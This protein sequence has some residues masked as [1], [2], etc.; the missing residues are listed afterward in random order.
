MR[1]FGFKGQSATHGTTKAERKIGSM[2][3][4]AGSMYATRVFKGKRMAGRM[5]NKR[6]T[7]QGL[8]VWKVVPKYNLLYCKGSIPGFR[9]CEVYIRDST[10]RKQEAFVQ[11]TP[12]P[13]PTCLPGHPHYDTDDELL[14]P[15]ASEPSL[16]LRTGKAPLKKR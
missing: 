9:G 12:P 7:V 14:C 16:N 11:H 10:C 6:R 4:S 8:M 5:G 2:G 15:A 13:F 3:G 1:R